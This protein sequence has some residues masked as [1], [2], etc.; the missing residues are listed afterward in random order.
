MFGE[1]DWFEVFFPKQ[2][3]GH[4]GDDLVIRRKTADMALIGKYFNQ[5]LASAFADVAPNP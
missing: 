4:F 2:K 5:R 3:A 1:S